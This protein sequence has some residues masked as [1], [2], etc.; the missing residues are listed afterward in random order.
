MKKSL[1]LVLLFVSNLAIAQEHSEQQIN[2]Y[3]P[4]Q[5]PKTWVFKS[6][7]NGKEKMIRTGDRVKVYLNRM[8][9]KD[10]YLIRGVLVDMNEHELVL[11]NKQNGQLLI[12]KKH[13][14]RIIASHKDGIMKN[15]L[16]L[17]LIGAG[18]LVGGIALLIV[19]FSIDSTNPGN[20]NVRSISILLGVAGLLL[21]AVGMKMMDD[22]ASNIVIKPFSGNWEITE[23]TPTGDVLPF[24]GQP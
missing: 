5:K 11:S 22:N 13:V 24:N 23:I 2:A 9:L 6:K 21:L 14:K 12:E 17:L 7:S 15:L 10:K 16:G 20:T 3:K 1:L 19:L 8:N 4:F 18:C